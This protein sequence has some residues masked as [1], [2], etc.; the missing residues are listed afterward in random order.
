M[1]SNNDVPL[2]VDLSR[3]RYDQSTYYGR[4]RHF[5]ETVN[6][7]NVLASGKKLEEAASVVKAYKYVPL[8]VETC[9]II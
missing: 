9:C 1:S 3:P 2:K 5:I 7:L 4:A 8:V 6:P